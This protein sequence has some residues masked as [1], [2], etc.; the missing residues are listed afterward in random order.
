MIDTY[1]ISSPYPGLRPFRRQESDLFFGR[2]EC[3]ATMV[4][5]LESSRFLAVLGASG[6][7]KSSLVKVGLIEALE[8]GSLQEAG[9]SWRVVQFKPQGKPMYE[10]AH[11]LLGE[12]AS[13]EQIEL[14]IAFLRRGPRSLLEWCETGQL[15]PRENLLIFVDQFEELFRYRT[16]AG[17]E[18]AEAFVA[19]LLRTKATRRL[20]IYVTLTM[21]SEF[22]GACALI[23][24]LA[25]AMNDGQ[26]L[27]PQMTRDQ[28]RA[29]IVGPARLGGFNVEEALVNRLLNDLATYSTSDDHLGEETKD[30]SAFSDVSS[31][32]DRFARRADQ[33]PLLQ[34]V[35]NGLYNWTAA[36]SPGERIVLKLHDYD[37]WGGL[38]GSLNLH[39][40]NIL[41]EVAKAL[42]HERAQEISAKLFRALISGTSPANAQRRP[43]QFSDL[44]KLCGNDDTAVR[45][46]IEAFR[47]AGRNFLTPDPSKRLNA[48][49]IIDISHESLIRQWTR[50]SAWLETEAQDAQSWRRLAEAA[51]DERKGIGGLLRG[52]NLQT[53]NFWHIH[54]HPTPEWVKRYGTTADDFKSAISFLERSRRMHWARRIGLACGILV[55]CLFFGGVSF[56]IVQ[57]NIARQRDALEYEKKRQIAEQEQLR[58]MQDATEKVSK[59]AESESKLAKI[60][61]ETSARQAGL[62]NKLFRTS[63]Q[64]F[65]KTAQQRMNGW[66]ESGS[67]IASLIDATPDIS[68]TRILKPLQGRMVAQYAFRPPQG[69][70]G[71]IELRTDTRG[72]YRL[73]LLSDQRVA[74]ID[75]R[76]R[77]RHREF[78]LTEFEPVDR[79]ANHS[80]SPDGNHALIVVTEAKSAD[81]GRQSRSAK[82]GIV[83]VTGRSDLPSKNVRAAEG[84]ERPDTL[85]VDWRGRRAIWSQ[86][87]DE[88]PEIVAIDFST[89][90]LSSARRAKQRL[91]IKCKTVFEID[92]STDNGFLATPLDKY[93]SCSRG[94]DDRKLR[95]KKLDGYFRVI[96]LTDKWAIIEM[97]IREVLFDPISK[98]VAMNIETGKART[99][100][101]SETELL[102]SENLAGEALASTRQSMSA[103]VTHTIRGRCTVTNE[104]PDRS[105]AADA[106][107]EVEVCLS[108]IDNSSGALLD[109][110]RYI[111]PSFG[112]KSAYTPIRIRKSDSDGSLAFEFSQRPSRWSIGIPRIGSLPA[113]AVPQLSRPAESTSSRVLQWTELGSVIDVAH[114]QRWHYQ[115]GSSSI[116]SLLV[117]DDAARVMTFQLG[118]DGT[119]MNPIQTRE[120]M[121]IAELVGTQRKG[122]LNLEDH[123]WLLSNATDKI[124]V[125]IGTR[126]HE[127]GSDGPSSAKPTVRSVDLENAPQSEGCRRRGEGQAASIQII[128]D[129]PGRDPSFL[130]QDS[131]GRVWSIP[132][133]NET[134]QIN[135]AKDSI[136][137]ASRSAAITEEETGKQVSVQQTRQSASE[138]EADTSSDVAKGIVCVVQ[139]PL[140]SPVIALDPTSGSL[141]V[142]LDKRMLHRVEAPKSNDTASLSVLEPI[143]ETPLDDDIVAATFVHSDQIAALHKAGALSIFS[144]N[145]GQWSSRL[146]N[147]VG[148]VSELN[149]SPSPNLL[150]SDNKLLIFHR[151]KGIIVDLDEN[152]D[153]PVVAAGSL[154]GS[155]DSIKLLGFKDGQIDIL[156]STQIL[157]IQ[158]PAIPPRDLL[159]RVLAARYPP[160][161]GAQVDMVQLQ[162]A[163]DSDGTAASP[164]VRGLL[165]LGDS[166]R[167]RE[168]LSAFFAREPFAEKSDKEQRSRFRKEIQ[169]SC[170]SK[171]PDA[172]NALLLQWISDAASLALEDDDLPWPRSASNILRAAESGNQTALSILAGWI[173]HGI[174]GTLDTRGAPSDAWA[175]LIHRAGGREREETNSV[176]DSEDDPDLTQLNAMQRDQN[177]TEKLREHSARLRNS[178]NPRI[179]DRIGDRMREG[180]LVTRRYALFHYSLAETLYTASGDDTN[181]R[182]SAEKRASIARVLSPNEILEEH[183][184]IA[185]W[186]ASVAQPPIPEDDLTRLRKDLKLLDSL[187]RSMKREE[188]TLVLSEIANRIALASRRADGS[189]VDESRR[190]SALLASSYGK[191]LADKTT[192]DVLNRWSEEFG[193]DR[194]FSATILA[195]LLSAIENEKGIELH[196]TSDLN[197]HKTVT[198]LIIENVQAGD[199]LYLTTLANNL[200]L[201]RNA[202]TRA[203]VQASE[204]ERMVA[205]ASTLKARDKL[206]T[207]LVEHDATNHN[208]LVHRGMGR[209]WMGVAAVNARRKNV[210]TIVEDL[211]GSPSSNLLNSATDLKAARAL[212]DRD[213][214]ALYRLTAAQRWL[215]LEATTI[216]F[217]SEGMDAISNFEALTKAAEEKRWA[218]PGGIASL[219]SEYANLFRNLSWHA[220]DLDKKLEEGWRAGDESVRV[221]SAGLILDALYYASWADRIAEEASNAPGSDYGTEPGTNRSFAFALSRLA[222]RLISEKGHTLQA[223]DCDKAAS[224]PDDPVRLAPSV[225]FENL[226]DISNFNAAKAACERTHQ[227]RRGDGRA[228]FL[229]ARVLYASRTKEEKKRGGE[230]FGEAAA[231]NYAIAFNNVAYQLPQDEGK[232]YYNIFIQLVLRDHFSATF[233]YLLSQARDEQH[234]KAL[235]WL[236]E[237][238]AKIGVAEA[239]EALA[240]GTSDP[241]KRKMHLL[242]G[243]RFSAGATK[244]RLTTRAKQILLSSGKEKNARRAATEFEPTPVSKFGDE[245]R[246][247]LKAVSGDIS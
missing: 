24:D 171:M 89:L 22:L 164:K 212:G 3:I 149:E 34:H 240:E 147:D 91:E 64:L 180:D 216:D 168:T 175:K 225:P 113:P 95:E 60:N 104:R 72:S 179:H 239:H 67:F 199:P 208:Y 2:E 66:E 204:P 137:G 88:V 143:S 138:R 209:L 44:V 12:T 75:A 6:S 120:V 127:I 220:Y 87:R 15:A 68:L 40:E 233:K 105:S 173:S 80:I 142:R 150:A 152:K 21:R 107:P 174:K 139:S 54:A 5:R 146:I 121:K 82:S 126:L 42:G 163:A 162:T 57:T 70:L 190:K 25:E 16:Y 114:D 214:E 28:C 219:L 8:R 141:L 244:L 73:V 39:A 31:Q 45:V 85:V 215:L 200:S 231:Q 172:A 243:A 237:Q 136:V 38:Q 92:R 210:G 156:S 10:L 13:R 227:E 77:A 196:R 123:P 7:G 213:F 235:H 76:T 96:S 140:A 26:F 101:R 187:A 20:P 195:K 193:S 50:L 18:E 116:K 161:R 41:T 186:T 98:L 55:A 106:G 58:I 247:K 100:L 1:S 144:R 151:N 166:N 23:D 182:A 135:V 155:P 181:S 132:S 185:N 169:E 43:V 242:I 218:A 125:G 19:L 238:A 178:L 117:S 198:E 11:A 56:L 109:S 236:A 160:A 202:F 59:A 129:W 128:R 46:V 108:F 124:M 30:G 224:H 14:M 94:A 153:L 61:Q 133:R 37:T 203:T 194:A 207:L 63:S 245:D 184:V 51:A 84:I 93:E 154:P 62:S 191:P 49:S 157:R 78:D 148:F 99:I 119:K 176:L 122:R 205:A 27:T 97:Q 183:N 36:R 90:E 79:Q 211:T 221:R 32:S 131:W 130:V 112:G 71:S 134:S 52:P 111:L 35:L 47:R 232:H 246:R 53:L 222:N 189:I 201:N 145:K 102:V 229:L 230:M 110:P 177:N 188:M 115:P 83:L 69:E 226:E 29:A 223:S 170:R 241:E 17:R 74:V 217:K 118:G 228:S 4:D 103:V 81:D 192:L 206:L 86:W 167:C 9:R 197:V 158:L 48:D 165:A 33:L 234:R 65:I 159:A